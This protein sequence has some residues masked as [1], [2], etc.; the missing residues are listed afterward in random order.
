LAEA[1]ET[2]FWQYKEQIPFNFKNKISAVQWE[3]KSS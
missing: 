3:S 1:T 2:G